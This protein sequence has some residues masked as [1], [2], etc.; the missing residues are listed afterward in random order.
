MDDDV[1]Y[2]DFQSHVTFKVMSCPGVGLANFGQEWDLSWNIGDELAGRMT[3][4]S[5]CFL[6]RCHVETMK[7]LDE[8]EGCDVLTQDRLVL[9]TWVSC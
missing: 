6:K 4:F 1:W 9:D 8:E 2:G 3:Y 7:N 5:S